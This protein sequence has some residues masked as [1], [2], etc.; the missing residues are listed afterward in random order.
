MHKFSK[1][2]SIQNI[3]ANTHIFALKYYMVPVLIVGK[4]LTSKFSFLPFNCDWNAHGPRN[5][6]PADW[7]R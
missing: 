6:R 4:I 3:H 2:T 5:H 7:R 1:M